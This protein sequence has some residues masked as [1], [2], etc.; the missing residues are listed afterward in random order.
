MSQRDSHPGTKGAERG[1]PE[2]PCPK[3]AVELTSEQEKVARTLLID[4]ATFETVALTFLGRGQR[5]R[6]EAIESYFLAHPEIAG[7]RAKHMLKVTREI[8]KSISE[9]D[10]DDI[11]LADA[12][13]ATG[14][15]GL[16][17]EQ[18]KLDVNDAIRR[19]LERQVLVLK[20]QLTVART[21]HER[22]ATRHLFAQTRA[23]DLDHEKARKGL[24][25]V[26]AKL[27]RTEKDKKLNHEVVNQIRE[28]Y[29]LIK[30]PLVPPIGAPQQ[31]AQQAGQPR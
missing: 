20:K 8:R 31:E 21:S 24:E 11:E 12:V 10:P 3:A 27:T 17:R 29:G 9:G 19:D 1:G 16:H 14:L 25:E 4:G 26:E 30:K 2:K 18:A 7:E 15:L 28:I 5:V 22:A 13:I 6:R 23:L